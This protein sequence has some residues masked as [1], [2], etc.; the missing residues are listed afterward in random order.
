[1][2]FAVE[3]YQY[4]QF[5]NGNAVEAMRKSALK[6]AVL[7]LGFIPFLTCSLPPYDEGLSLGIETARKMADLGA[8]RV[9][10]G[11]LWV[12][13][14][15]FRNRDYYFMPGKGFGPDDF[16]SGFIVS[17]DERSFDVSYVEY[18]MGP[19][20]DFFYY[21][22]WGSDI[23][24]ADPNRLNFHAETVKWGPFLSFIRFDANNYDENWYFLL[25]WPPPFPP[26]WQLTDQHL[27]PFIHGDPEAFG[28][29][30][31]KEPSI[32]GS[33]IWPRPQIDGFDEQVFFCRFDTTGLFAEV[34]YHTDP[35]GGIIPPP[36]P[37]TPSAII[38]DDLDFNFPDYFENAF[39]YRD[40]FTDI[41]YLS[42][43][44]ETQRKFKNYRWG[45]GGPGA[46]LTPLI[47]MDRRIDAALSN[48][49]LLSF[50]NNRCYVYN[51]DGEKLYDFLLGGLHF[52][53]E[54]YFGGIPHVVFTLPAWLGL[55]NQQ[56]ELYFNVYALPTDLLSD[57]R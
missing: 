46:A 53:Y 27:Q 47:K 21:R 2:A 44:S 11:P 37:P 24:N 12:W 7:V 16:K 52:C 19:P 23:T 25:T 20:E 45:P 40:G 28:G 3:R 4:Y 34:I 18:M 33:S 29:V 10:V 50:E 17:V 39:Y 38:R 56:D 5:Q 55:R 41:S 51:S 42:Y 32:I 35:G 54:I 57:L 31:G 15:D 14:F 49:T 9:T 8:M 22:G 36:P 13:D 26:D 30:V 6:I 1:L 48:G 43:Y